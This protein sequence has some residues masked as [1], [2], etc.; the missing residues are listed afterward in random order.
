MQSMPSIPRLEPVTIKAASLSVETRIEVIASVL[1]CV[2]YDARQ[3][4]DGIPHVP[5]MR[6]ERDV[7]RIYEAIGRQAATC[8]LNPSRVVEAKRKAVEDAVTIMG[9]YDEVDVDDQRP[10]PMDVRRKRIESACLSAIHR[11]HVELAREE[12]R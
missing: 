8:I 4:Q 7:Q 1:A 3:M 10:V 12:R 6:A 2:L 9:H 11:Y 5:L